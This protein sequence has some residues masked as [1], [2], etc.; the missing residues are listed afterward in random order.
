ML[1][2][3]SERFRVARLLS[4]FFWHSQKVGRSSIDHFRRR[5]VSAA[6]SA[7]T[8]FE[9]RSF[10]RQALTLGRTEIGRRIA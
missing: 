7:A 8:F 3:K 1:F 9:Q 2:G 6:C 10:E 5:Y 4:P